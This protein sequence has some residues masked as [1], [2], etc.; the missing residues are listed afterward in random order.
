MGSWVA[1]GDD[2][3]VAAGLA[4]AARDRSGTPLFCG[5]AIADPL[6]GMHAAV[7]AQASWRAGGGHLLDVSLRDV[8]AHCLLFEGGEAK[9]SSALEPELE[10][11]GL[12]YRVRVGRASSAVGSPH[13]RTPEGCVRPLGADTQ[14]VLRELVVGC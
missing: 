4:Y 13:A 10:M 7:A 8:T 14:A 6:T 1:F 5:D 12:T 11:D 2:A 9:A 3:A